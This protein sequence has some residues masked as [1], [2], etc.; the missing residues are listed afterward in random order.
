MEKGMRPEE[1]L[2]LRQ[3]EIRIKQLNNYK[4]LAGTPGIVDLLEWCRRN[5]RQTNDALST[6]R[7]L[8]EAGRTA[9]RLAMLEK[10]EVLLYFVGLFDPQAE[11]DSI[12]KELT[13]HTQSFEDYQQDR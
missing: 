1:G 2:E 8:H 3:I 10:K 5:I 7:E 9:E 6:D 12:E 11:L 4:D 13:D